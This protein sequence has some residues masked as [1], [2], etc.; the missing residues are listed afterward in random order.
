MNPFHEVITFMNPFYVSA[1]LFLM[2]TEYWERNLRGILL[3]NEY[4]I[5]NTIP[6]SMRFSSMDVE[7]TENSI[8]FVAAIIATGINGTSFFTAAPP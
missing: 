7:S 5:A 4:T 3:I 6:L 1:G 2:E 8:S